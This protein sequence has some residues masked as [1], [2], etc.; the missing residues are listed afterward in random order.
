MGFALGLSVG[1]AG[2]A[3]AS[4]R[5][6]LPRG[7]RRV[8]V[9][10]ALPA[11]NRQRQTER[12]EEGGVAAVERAAPAP[13]SAAAQAAQP[14]DAAALNSITLHEGAGGGARVG[15]KGGKGEGHGEGE[16]HAPDDALSASTE[17][18][19][20]AAARHIQRVVRWLRLVTGVALCAVGVLAAVLLGMSWHN[21]GHGA[22]REDSAD[23]GAMAV[24]LGLPLCLLVLVWSTLACQRYQ[25]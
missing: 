13:A 5:C 6:P 19:G 18:I 9:G 21:T 22:N 15:G 20:G 16:G 12:H 1:V 8:E 23:A 17:R 14:L 11:A 3:A 2:Q 25:T 24:L 10:G 7:L 4:A